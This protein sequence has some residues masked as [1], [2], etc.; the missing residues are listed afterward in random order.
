MT[1]DVL[2]RRQKTRKTNATVSEGSYSTSGMGLRK[3]ISESVKKA[4]S[5][6]TRLRSLTDSGLAYS[7]L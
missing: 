2:V 4:F 7:V 5:L 3:L 6:M 1:N